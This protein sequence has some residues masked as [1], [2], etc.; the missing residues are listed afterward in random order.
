MVGGLF[1]EARWIR[2]FPVFLTV[3]AIFG[4]GWALNRRKTEVCDDSGRN[5]VATQGGH[6]LYFIPVEYWSVIAL[7]AGII[8]IINT[9]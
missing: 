9:W 3:L 7:I 1:P 2:I 5:S 4:L 8:M 6:S